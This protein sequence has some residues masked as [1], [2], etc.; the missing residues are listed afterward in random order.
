M[1]EATPTLTIF[2]KAFRLLSPRNFLNFFFPDVKKFV[3]ATSKAIE[4]YVE[5]NRGLLP[6]SYPLSFT[7]RTV[8]EWFEEYGLPYIADEP[9]ELQRNKIYT[10]WRLVGAQNPVYLRARLQEQFPLV[11]FVERT[12]PDGLPDPFYYQLTGEI[13]LET[14][15]AELRTL[16][17]K[18]FPLHLELVPLVD[19]R[20]LIESCRVGVA[21]TGASITNKEIGIFDV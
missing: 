18:I 2:E 13:D 1:A 15:E 11:D 6:E 14:Q 16:I 20:E 5:F 9:L 8:Q 3:K 17:Q 10:L 4:D 7:I 12:D 19:V 21:I